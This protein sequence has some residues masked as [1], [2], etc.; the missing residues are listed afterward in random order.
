MDEVGLVVETDDLLDT[1]GVYLVGLLFVDTA[2]PLSRST[3]VD[4][5]GHSAPRWVWQQVT[6]PL[7]LHCVLPIH[8][9][10]LQ[11]SL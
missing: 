11:L 8:L 3:M 10:L 7:V 1:V 4:T 5:M 2:L 9:V 6:H